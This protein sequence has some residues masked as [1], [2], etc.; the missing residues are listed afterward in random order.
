MSSIS[1][2]TL[3]TEFFDI[4]SS[5]LLVQ[6]EPQYLVGALMKSAMG[7]SLAQESDMG[8]PFRMLGGAGAAYGSADDDRLQLEQRAIAAQAVIVVPELG[9]PPGHTV[10]LNRPAYTDSTYTEAARL[11]PTGSTISTTPISLGSEQTSITIKRFGGPYSGGV[12]PYG[13]AKFDAGMALHKLASVAGR[14][15]KRDYDKWIDAVG[16]AL[17]SSGANTIRPLGF[18]ADTDGLV[19]GDMPMDFETLTRVELKMD[20]LNIPFFSNGKRICILHPRQI[21]Q[22]KADP[23][24]Q[25]LGVFTNPKNP[26]WTSHVAT[27]GNLDVYQSNTLTTASSTTTIYRGVAFGPGMVACGVSRLPEVVPSTADNYGED[28]LVVWLTYMGFLVSDNR[29]GVLVSTN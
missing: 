20:E 18:T 3:P 14:H 19:A 22:L 2:S 8:L 1:R 27:V 7:A 26:L 9:K 23:A 15:L 21:Q 6:P 13:L 24:F 25:R 10:R 12:A 4:T 5:M 16:V 11:I 17:F 28:I 29:F